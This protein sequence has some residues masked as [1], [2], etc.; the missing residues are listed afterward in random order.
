MSK[1]LDPTGQPTYGLGICARC[2]KKFFLADLM[3]DPNTPNLMVCK[4]DVDEYDPYR[5]APRS[6]DPITLPFVR[7]DSAI[8]TH[9]SGVLTEDQ[10]EFIVSENNTMLF[11]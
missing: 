2:S 7:P 11:K 4:D 10:T 9:P 1:F 3:S 8:D 5:L 6:A